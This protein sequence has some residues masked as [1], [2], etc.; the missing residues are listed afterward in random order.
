[1]SYVPFT[2]PTPSFTFIT[3]PF[4]F[5]A[6]STFLSPHNH[7]QSCTTPSPF[8]HPPP[9]SPHTHLPAPVTFPTPTYLPCVAG[10][11]H[12]LV[13]LLNSLLCGAHSLC[14]VTHCFPCVYFFGLYSPQST[15]KVQWPI[16]GVHSIMMEKSALAVEGSGCT[17]HPLSLYL[18][19]RTKLQCIRSN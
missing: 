4:T 15:H 3:H 7:T 8:P 2:F 17:P 9:S 13:P 16:S 11:S 18:P 19:S 10:A 6:T 1:M 12:P 5:P 14:Q